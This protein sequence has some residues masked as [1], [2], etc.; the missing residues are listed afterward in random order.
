VR[1]TKVVTTIVDLFIIGGGINGT[2]IAADAAG[3]GLSVILC[4]QDD[5][6]S[7]TSSAS[8][9]LIHGGLRYLEQYDFL[10]VHKALKEREILWHKAPHLIAPLR[11]VLPYEKVLRPKWMLRIGMWLYDHLSKRQYLPPSQAIALTPDTYGA[12]LKPEFKEGFIYSDCWADDARLVVLN[13]LA[14][15]EHG[16]QIYTRQAVTRVQ[17]QDNHWLITT[18]DQQTQREKQYQARLLINASGPWVKICQQQLLPER[19]SI[20]IELVKGSHIVVKRLYPGNHAY[21][22]MNQDGRVILVLPFLNDYT[23][24]GTTDIFY[25]GDPHTVQI[26]P[27]EI[28]Y[29]CDAVNHFFQ[30]PLTSAEVIW[31]YSGVRPLQGGNKQNPSHISREYV[32]QWDKTPQQ[33]PLLNIIGG[34]IT[35][36]RKLAEEVVDS[37]TSYFPQMGPSWTAHIPLPGGDLPQKDF[38][39]FVEQCR[40]QYAWLPVTLCERYAHQYG[41]RI[42]QLLV[43]A[44][45]LSELGRDFGHGLYTLEIDFL[46][47][48]EWAMTAEDIL[49]R[50]TKLGMVFGEGEIKKLEEYLL[51]CHP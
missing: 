41:T 4:E 45:A 50:R 27:A 2:G 19:Q 31:S 47:Q 34:K 1:G 29:L 25:T 30:K 16:A 23:L 44:H 17:A 26:T 39:Q 35:T 24:I 13:A 36:Y 9:K 46:V 10:L 38:A 12:A 21:M 8:T 6:A 11:F 7:G 20:A 22:L 5:L 3:R 48:H 18:Y 42:H 51:T 15:T 14:A 32:L 37:L 40:K 33:P 49:W 43:N 28:T